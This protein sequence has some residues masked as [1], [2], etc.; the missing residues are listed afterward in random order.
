[1]GAGAHKM[2]DLW[3]SDEDICGTSW[4]HQYTD[5]ARNEQGDQTVP[6]TTE[7]HQ[8]DGF[9]DWTQLAG[10]LNIES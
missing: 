4:A 7:S 5:E 8:S 3:P 9:H 1:M 6:S 10:T 2:E